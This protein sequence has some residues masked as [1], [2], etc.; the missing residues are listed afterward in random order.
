MENCGCDK[1]KQQEKQTSQQPSNQTSNQ[2]LHKQATGQTAEATSQIRGLF[3]NPLQ[4]P[5][6]MHYHATNQPGKSSLLLHKILPRGLL[7]A[8][9]YFKRL[10]S[11][12]DDCNRHGHSRVILSTS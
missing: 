5:G 7:V 6:Q 10:T 11:E 4:S 1:Q 9:F 2:A 12:Q 8:N 3:L